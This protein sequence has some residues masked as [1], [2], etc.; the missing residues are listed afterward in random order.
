[1]KKVL[2]P[3]IFLSLTACNSN[4]NE[5]VNLV[6][7]EYKVLDCDILK[8]EQDLITQMIEE[9]E[10]S[11]NKT[12]AVNFAIGLLSVVTTGSGNFSGTDNNNLNKYK[13]RLEAINNLIDKCPR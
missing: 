11:L 1:M 10:R 8:M 12:N 6:E 3:A 13:I 7:D 9:E 4:Y 5:Q 2:L